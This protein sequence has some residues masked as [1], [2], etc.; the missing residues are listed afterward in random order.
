[1]RVSCSVVI[2]AVPRMMPWQ[3]YFYNDYDPSSS[4]GYDYIITYS[5]CFHLGSAALWCLLVLLLSL[6]L[7]P[8]LLLL[9]VLLL[10]FLA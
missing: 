6:L 1:M 10:L 4:N 5:S 2:I 9:L 3:E 8:L 7:L